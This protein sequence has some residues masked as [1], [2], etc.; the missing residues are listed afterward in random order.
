MVKETKTNAVRMLDKMKI[1]YKEHH[2]TDKGLG[3]KSESSF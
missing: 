3:G 2:Y 1:E